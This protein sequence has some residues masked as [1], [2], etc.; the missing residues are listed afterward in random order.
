MIHPG[1]G[2]CEVYTS[3]ANKLSEHFSCYG[4]D[5]YNLYSSNKIDNLNQL[6]NL[7]MKQKH[8]RTLTKIPLR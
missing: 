4:V 1:R 2:G 8:L 3:L 6:A 5:S 7:Y